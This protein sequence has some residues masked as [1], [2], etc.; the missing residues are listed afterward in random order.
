MYVCAGGSGVRS[1]VVVAVYGGAQGNGKRVC[2][3]KP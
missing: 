2:A 1:G 3:A